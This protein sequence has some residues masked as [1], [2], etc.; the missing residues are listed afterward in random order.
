[1][2]IENRAIALLQAAV[3]TDSKDAPA[4]VSQVSARD[5]NMDASID[6]LV[7]KA[8]E[9]AVLDFTKDG[10]GFSCKSNYDETSTIFFSVPYDTGWSATIDGNEAHIVQSGGL[11]LLEVPEG[12]HDIVFTYVTPY[13]RIGLF[14]SLACWVLFLILLAINKPKNI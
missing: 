10:H 6:E 3:V 7:N 1:M 2:P 8:K 11:M 4:S 14:I 12:Q 13:Y 9:N 5:I